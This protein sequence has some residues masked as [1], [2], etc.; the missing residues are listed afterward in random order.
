MRIAISGTHF[1]GK[2]TLISA[3]LK[4]LPNYTS[5]EE[6][7]VLLEEQG[8][9]FSNPLSMDDFEQQFDCSI[10]S[11]EESRNNTLF[12]RCPLDSLAYSLSLDEPIDTKDW[13][14]KMENAIQLLD[15]IVFIPIENRDR[16]HVP[17]SED[18]ELRKNVDV[19]L[20]DM[21]LNDSLG[22]LK[23]IEILEVAGSIE[24]RVR[25]VIA[26]LEGASNDT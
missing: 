23:N 24:K 17:A 10:Q 1:S 3:L 4:Q 19:R 15:L 6:P 11:I 5:V 12:D 18:L 13:I 9:E 21:L 16:I 2:S 20:H 26:K 22:I 8:Y 7:Y 14:Q 25:M